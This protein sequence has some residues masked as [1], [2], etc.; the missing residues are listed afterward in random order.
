VAVVDDDGEVA[1]G[2]E[3]LEDDVGAYKSERARRVGSVR[4]KERA[5]C[6]TDSED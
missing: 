4:W 2:E 6:V 5:C 3:K 1:A